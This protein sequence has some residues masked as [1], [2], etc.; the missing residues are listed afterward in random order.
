MDNN[1]TI[2]AYNRYARLY[3][4]E[5]VDFWKNFPQSFLSRFSVHMPG[6][7]VLDVGSGSGRDA[8]LLRELGYQVVCQDGSESMVAMTKKLGFESV[9]ADFSAIDFPATSF[10]GVWAY[11][12][13]I[14]IP[15]ED[16]A[17]VIQRLRTLLKPNGVLVIGV[18]EGLAAGMVT[19]KTMPD[20]TRYFKNYTRQELRSLIGPLGFEFLYEDDYRPGSKKVYLNHLYRVAPSPPEA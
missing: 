19:R 6:T 17:R 16:A 5:V 15:K 11:T 1:T 10:D 12:S 14:H 9:V 7:R 4:E 20:A 13:L 18:I 8:L 2:D 3:D